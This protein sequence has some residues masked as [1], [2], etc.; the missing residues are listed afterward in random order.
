MMRL[1]VSRSTRK[2]DVPESTSDPAGADAARWDRLTGRGGA[3]APRTSTIIS[4]RPGVL[5]LSTLVVV[6]LSATLILSSA[7][8][9]RRPGEF[10]LHEGRGE[11]NFK[12]GGGSGIGAEIR[13]IVKEGEKE[14][15]AAA[16]KILHPIMPTHEELER[17]R[18][19]SAQGFEPNLLQAGYRL[20]RSGEW[21]QSIRTKICQSHAM[22]NLESVR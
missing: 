6:A 9:S 16:H 21:S 18:E 3:S 10:S 7:D 14:I 1:I 4:N 12:E 15:A 8:V 5:V 20:P 2:T 11:S 19:L 13:G 22:N 17:E